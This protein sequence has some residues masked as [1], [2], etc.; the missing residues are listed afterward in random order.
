MLD[1]ILV[2]DVLNEAMKTGGDF[3]EVFFEDSIVNSIKMGGRKIEHS[4][5]A[6]EFGVGIR[7]FKEFFCSYVSTNDISREGLLKAASKAARAIEG[8]NRNIVVNLVEQK[9][10]NRHRIMFD[11]LDI[12]KDEKKSYLSEVS[13]KAYNLS[14]KIKRVDAIITDKRQNV[15]IA[16]TEGLWVEDERV[17]TSFGV[18]AIAFDGDDQFENMS[19]RAAMSGFEL[20]KDLDLDFL[21]EGA[22][23]GAVEQL[24]AVNCPVGKMPVIIGNDGGVLFH[25]A[26]GHALEATSVAKK[27]SIFADS[28]GQK[29]AHETV[30]LVDDGT[31]PNAWGSLNVDDEGVKT[32]R[33]VLIEKGV[34][35]GFLVDRFNAIKMQTSPT[36]NSRRQNYTFAP[37]SR[38]TNTFILEGK[39]TKDDLISSVD[40]G[41]YISRF[42]GGSVNPQTGDFN[43]SVL[44]SYLIENGKI[45]KPV[46][47]AKLIGN[48][49]D[50]LQNIDMVAG[51]WDLHGGGRC[52]SVSGWV[53]VCMGQPSLRISNITV[54][55][56][57]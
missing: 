29:I 15:T 39:S 4:S 36:G 40:T 55:G 7:V 13:D 20:V 47:G 25:E 34:L 51:D 26:C 43:F 21:A 10:S 17:Y 1:K 11:P 9:I 16:N 50:I 46:K 5:S 12:A 19:R 57:K 35:K 31:I 28:L 49:R 56:Q 8:I 45:T 14:S 30:T 3:A 24:S 48:S 41:L 54:G 44:N 6:N 38:M 52:G 53:P 42:G 22:V 32:K 33:N 27:S 23:S 2:L 18:T 37:T